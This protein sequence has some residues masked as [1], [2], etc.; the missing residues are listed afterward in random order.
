MPNLFYEKLLYSILGA[1]TEQSDYSL[2]QNACLNKIS[3][4]KQNTLSLKL[5]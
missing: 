4:P 1:Y 5:V 3:I 2:F